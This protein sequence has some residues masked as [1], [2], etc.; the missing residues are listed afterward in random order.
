MT[1]STPGMASALRGVDLH[2]LRVGVRAAHDVQVQHARELDVVDVVALAADEARI[3]LA[4][5]RVAHAAD[6]GDVGRLRSPW[7][8]SL[9]LQR[10]LRRRVLDGLDDVDVAGAAAQVA[11]DRL[12]DLVLARVRVAS[13][14]SA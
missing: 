6:F 11:G 3:L 9:P 10:Q 2:D 4:L 12:A 8:A 7:R 5:H 14:S 1:A 13:A